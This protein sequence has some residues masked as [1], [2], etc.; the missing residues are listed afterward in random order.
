M[1]EHLAPVVER[2]LAIRGQ[3]GPDKPV[4][5]SAVVVRLTYN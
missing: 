2:R 1:F 3:E 5:S 4:G